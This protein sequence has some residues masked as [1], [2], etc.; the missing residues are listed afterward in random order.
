ME[1]TFEQEKSKAID[2][3]LNTRELSTLADIKN[4]VTRQKDELDY[5][6]VSEYQYC[7]L[8]SRFDTLTEIENLI[9]EKIKN[10]KG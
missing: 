6:N 5:K 8:S 9:N 3:L 2:I 4:Y 1:T 10:L 7:S